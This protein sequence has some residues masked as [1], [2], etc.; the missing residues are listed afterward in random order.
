MGRGKKR[1]VAKHRTEQKNRRGIRIKMGKPLFFTLTHCCKKLMGLTDR[2]NYKSN[3]HK[4]VYKDARFCNARY[5]SSIITQCNFNNTR[6]IGIDFFNTNLKGSSFKN[7]YLKD[8]VFYNCN[9]RDVDFR[10]GNLT[11]VIFICTNISAAKNL[12]EISDG[13]TVYRSYPKFQLE[14][15]LES[16]LLALAT[17]NSI[18]KYNVLHVN[19]HKLNYWF[20]QMIKD[21]YGIEVIEQLADSLTI[22]Q[23]RKHLFTVWSYRKLIVKNGRS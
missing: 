12:E 7:A 10:G 20:L 18:S 16:K 4:L 11:N 23:N 14:P 5:Q 6:L 15:A 17:Y 22:A 1:Q 9:L 21:A 3:L 13:F 2:Y 19:K 8:V